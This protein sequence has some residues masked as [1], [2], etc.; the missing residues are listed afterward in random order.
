ML[1]LK[2]WQRLS[3]GLDWREF[4]LERALDE[5]SSNLRHQT[6]TGRP[7][8]SDRFVAVTGGQLSRDLQTRPVGRP[9]LG[10]AKE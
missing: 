8:G 2:S 6:M 1:D 4:L 3:D 5:E 7:L 10:T 9:S